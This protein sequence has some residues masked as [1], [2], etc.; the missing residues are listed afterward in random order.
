MEKTCKAHHYGGIHGICVL[1]KEKYEGNIHIIDD[2]TSESILWLKVD[3]QAFNFEFVIGSVYVPHEGSIYHN[4]SIFEHL[5][6]DYISIKSKYDLPVCLLGDFNA[7]TGTFS[8]FLPIDE[9]VADEAGLYHFT[10]TEFELESQGVCTKR[11]SCDKT[12]NNNGH[13]L[14]ELCKSLDIH[15]VIGR[16]GDDLGIGLVLMPVL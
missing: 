11:Y 7:R 14:I 9:A 5:A 13:S 8:D 15:I 3:K 16:V 2:T 12:T 1:F 4:N 10:N 6:D